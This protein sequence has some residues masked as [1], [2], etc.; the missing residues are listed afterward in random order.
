MASY[1]DNNLAMAFLPVTICRWAGRAVAASARWVTR[2]CF[3]CLLAKPQLVEGL[4]VR[5]ITARD[6]KISWNPA[7]SSCANAAAYDV[8]LLEV[9][10]AAIPGAPAVAGAG[11]KWRRL[12]VAVDETTC[13][14]RDLHSDHL[15]RVR[16][17]TRNSRGAGAFTESVEVR[18]LRVPSLGAGST[19]PLA[20][21]GL[22]TWE[23]TP[24]E[25]TLR[26]PLP[27]SVA[28]GRGLQ[29]TYATDRVTIR[30]KVTGEVVLD[31]ETRHKLRPD[32]CVWSR[33]PDTGEVLVE[34]EKSVPLMDAPFNWSSV[35]AGHPEIDCSRLKRDGGGGDGGGGGGGGSDDEPTSEYMEDLL[36]GLNLPDQHAQA[37]RRLRGGGG[38]GGR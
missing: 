31:G 21:G 15:Y 35:F 9:G 37:R 17:R 28:T 36:E 11:A 38:R 8:E 30:N 33:D 22:Y 26:L 24:K 2:T 6:F 25:I 29:V 5:R 16:V 14:A 4:R 32:G 19:G 7:R 13:I 20:N 10:A 12:K 34:L 3:V 18:T 23:Q 1:S 27:E